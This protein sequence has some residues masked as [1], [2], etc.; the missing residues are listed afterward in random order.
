M[1]RLAALLLGGLLLVTLDT[2]AHGA[3]V[4]GEGHCTD[5]D[6]V[7]VVVDFQELDHPTIIRCVSGLPDGATGYDALVAALGQPPTGTI[8]DGPGFVCRIDG[9]PAA[10]DDL[11]IGGSA[12]REDCVL[13]PPR[14]A[15]WS[16]WHASNGEE[17]SYA[18]FGIA[19][20]AVTPG[21]FEGWSYALNRSEDSPP[22]P[23]VSPTRPVDTPAATPTTAS[24]L[25]PSEMPEATDEVPMGTLA[26][27]GFVGAAALAGGVVWWRRR[28]G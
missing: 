20:R 24:S 28:E 10:D 14:E 15:F 23:R 21:S 26:G 17:W 7:T 1:R 13:T 2:G 9:R 18:S 4:S 8:K 22:A 12:Y 25:P 11:V 19:N 6:S 27:V 16:Y 5:D 3:P